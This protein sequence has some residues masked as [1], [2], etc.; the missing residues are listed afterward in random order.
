MNTGE[1]PGNAQS[2]RG[3]GLVLVAREL[4]LCHLRGCFFQRLP[5]QGGGSKL[6]HRRLWQQRGSTWGAWIFM[7]CA[8][9]KGALHG[10]RG[11]VP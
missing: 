4:P 10:G 6:P 8:A 11:G 2:M 3:T 5:R 9:E 1:R 7:A